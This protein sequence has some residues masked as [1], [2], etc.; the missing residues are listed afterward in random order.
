MQT[1][2]VYMSGNE[3]SVNITK[4]TTKSLEDFGIE[5]ELFDGV[6]GRDGIKILN[7]LNIVPSAYVEKRDWTD[8]IIGCLASHVLLWEECSRQEESYLIIE[9]DGVLIKDP[10]SLLP[11]IDTV[12]HLDAYLPFD[13]SKTASTALEYFQLYNERVALEE[14]GVK[15]YPKN[16]FYDDNNIT[17]SCFRGTYGYIITP[18]GAKEVLDFIKTKGAFPSDRCLC[19]KATHL[20]R[21]NSTYVRLN[22]FFNSL[23]VQRKWSLRIP[24]AI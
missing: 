22:P 17:G 20:Q 24:G 14:P 18:K 23:D 10:R 16:K 8:G 15:N 5:Y 1:R 21:S 9:Q 6:K 2:V 11:L 12:C 4:E 3:F 19:S 7:N 13:N